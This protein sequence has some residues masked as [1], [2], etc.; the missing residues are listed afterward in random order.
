MRRE[1]TWQAVVSAVVVSALVSASYP[2]V[3]LKLGLGPNVS[4]VSAFLGALML[5]ALAP[6]TH[7]QNRWMNN[8]VQ[9]AGTSAAQ[10][11]F[12]CVIA[13]AVEMAATNPAMNSE[14]MD[15]VTRLEP[16]PMF[17]WLLLRRRHRRA[18]HGP[19]PPPLHRRPENDLRRRR[20]RRRNHRRPR[21]QGAGGRQQA[22]DAR[23]D[24]P[25][26]GRPRFSPRGAGT[27]RELVP[28]S[29]VRLLLVGIE[30]SFLTLGSGLLIGLNV[31]LSLLAAT[32]VYQATGPVMVQ[33]GI[34]RDIALSSFSPET[35]DRAETLI[36]KRWGELTDDDK[37]FITSAGAARPWPT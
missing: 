26:L 18:L 34:A 4:V 5:L 6:K 14:K 15:H 12:M 24:R 23:S 21:Q 33:D 10:T 30:W 29:L 7:G 28:D 22:E 1:L 35:R 19:L 37:A 16:W 25:R 8:I 2:Y 17:W 20:R 13:A 32:V 31:G 3:V 27:H 11:A 9:T 36:D